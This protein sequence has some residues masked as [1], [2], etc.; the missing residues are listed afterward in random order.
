MMDEQKP[1]SGEQIFRIA[2]IEVAMSQIDDKIVGVF[3]FESSG[4][5]KRGPILL[6]IAEI[7]ATGYVYDKLIDVVNEEAERSRNLTIE[8]DADPVT[9]F[10]KIVQNLNNSVAGFLE[11]EPTPIN[12]TR[13]NMFVLELSEGHLCLTGRG[14][15]MNMFLQKQADGSYNT[16]DLFGSLE[17]PVD[18][19]PKKVF[20]SIICGDVKI[21]D[22]LIAG[23]RNLDRLRNELRMR[24]RLTTLPPVTA[25]LEIR[26]DL[27]RQAI[28]DDFVAVVVASLAAD[29][30]KTAEPIPTPQGRS[31]ASIERL[32][33]TEA[34]TTR[35]L[36]PSI[37]PR[38]AD[39]T[40]GEPLAPIV[41]GPLGLLS[42]LRRIVSKERVR[43]V[44]AL[45]SLRGM[46]AG[47]GTFLTKKRKSV[48]IGVVVLTLLILVVGSLVKYQR[49][50]AAE[51][52]AWNSTYDSARSLVE[53]AQGESV[54]SEDKARQ[55]LAD[56][57]GLLNGL[58]ASTNDRKQ[59]VDRLKTEAGELKQKLRRLVEVAQPTQLYALPD[60]IADGALV[61]PVIFKGSL[62]VADRSSR[63][64]AV[65]NLQTRDVK[66][67]T[68]TASSTGE[69]AAIA[70]GR[71]NVI[72]ALDDGKL[73][74]ANIASSET[75]KLN[76]G[77]GKAQSMTDIVWY[78]NR[79][80]RLDAAGGQIWRYPGASGGFGAE[81]TYLQ[82]ASTN[83]NDAVSLAIDS[84]VYV[85]KSN[86]QVARFYAGGQD[87]FALAPIDPPLQNGS[88][89]WTVA[90]GQY[91][92]IADATGKRVL[93]FTKE[94]RLVAQYTS[95]IFKG[96]RDI[97]VDE[98]AK[99]MYVVDG[100][101]LY[102]LALP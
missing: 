23:S 29:Q 74:A 51:R 34:A 90:D 98:A 9:R 73:L 45:A 7:H 72:L 48:L 16:Y 83:L 30:P 49:G 92:A 97:T 33:E 35:R 39:T 22:I 59:A 44:A 65:L 52:A 76:L 54:Y 78:A 60:G 20:A 71:E 28:P 91:V 40:V 69:V 27:E 41:G 95:P 31:T 86:G 3:R 56:A 36:A 87:G 57:D 15:L 75:G 62:V 25:S 32:R 101:A 14:E 88:G 18:L 37:A 46:N 89:I 67:I 24:E 47:F 26:Q 81:Q 93:L 12:W 84:N 43:D 77:S 17:Q 100:N 96:P 21:G 10:E 63:S 53:R 58:D 61:S 94:G 2:D 1:A 8:V 50:R 4:P 19:N 82:A 102:E 38:N 11:S 55:S 13:I 68:L 42:R 66:K 6:V 85:L 70:P 64:L 99:K 80:Y 79:L 5:K